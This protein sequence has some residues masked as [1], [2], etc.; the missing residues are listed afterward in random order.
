M[1]WPLRPPAEVAATVPALTGS[2]RRPLAV[3]QACSSAATGSVTIVPS[4]ARC[5]AARRSAAD[6]DALYGWGSSR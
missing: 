2:P 3:I 5:A 6:T 1:P 4:A